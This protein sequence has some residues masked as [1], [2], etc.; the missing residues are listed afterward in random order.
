MTQE[1][2]IYNMVQKKSKFNEF[3]GLNFEFFVHRREKYAKLNK[4]EQ[5]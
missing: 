4:I 2:I 5:K 3:Y 1:R